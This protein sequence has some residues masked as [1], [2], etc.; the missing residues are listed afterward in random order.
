MLN[1]AAC[2]SE[3]ALAIVNAETLN[4]SNYTLAT[5]TLLDKLI[6]R[7]LVHDRGL[8]GE[9][10]T[11]V[12]LTLARDQAT[13]PNGSSGSFIHTRKTSALEVKSISLMAILDDPLGDSLGGVSMQQLPGFAK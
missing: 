5:R 10:F 2:P 8:Q 7:A 11:R 3:P 6:L 4:Q 13:I 1:V 9:L 12:L